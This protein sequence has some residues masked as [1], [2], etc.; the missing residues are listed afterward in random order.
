MV[1][2]FITLWTE[3]F[4]DLFKEFLDKNGSTDAK[5]T[6]DKKEHNDDTSLAFHEQQSEVL[7]VHVVDADN[8]LGVKIGEFCVVIVDENEG[9]VCVG[10]SNWEC[11]DFIPAGR[12][13]YNGLTVPICAVM[14]L[15][16]ML[17]NNL[18]P[19][20]LT[21]GSMV[22][23]CTKIVTRVDSEVCH[24][25]VI[26]WNGGISWFAC[27]PTESDVSIICNMIRSWCSSCNLTSN[28]AQSESVSALSGLNEPVFH[29][30]IT[31]FVLFVGS[32]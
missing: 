14:P 13:L 21:G 3:A 31:V 25:E 20:V 1:T 12:G 2:T 22:N 23:M 4:F 15:N 19:N 32:A 28:M 26:L 18:S 9:H 30:N 29:V 8:V 5:N 27:G 10:W 16:G 24:T 11:W 6:E 17:M 7:I